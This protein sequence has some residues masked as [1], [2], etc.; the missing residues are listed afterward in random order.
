[1][2]RP[3]LIIIV[4]ITLSKFAKAQ[5]DSAQYE[6][7]DST[8]FEDRPNYIGFNLSPLVTGIVGDYNK[9]VK[10]TLIYK[11]NIGYK[12]LRFSLNH[13]RTVHPYPYNS[14]KVIS[15]T[16]TSY[17]ARFNTHDYQSIDVRMGIEELRGYRHARL[18]IGADVILGYASYGES[19]YDKNVV[20]DS[21][22]VYRIEDTDFNT[23]TGY[24]DGTYFNFGVDVSFGF[25]WFLSDDFLFTFQ[26]TPQFNYNFK[27]DGTKSDDLNVLPD[28]RNFADFKL[29]YFDVML[30]YKF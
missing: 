25:D 7:D 2:L 14:Y 15:T 4:V 17:Y 22:G 28:P 27:I 20:M 9:D 30:V 8:Y 3:L 19:Y 21:A 18:H 26:I 1:M 23:P 29:T 12:N 10:F 6:I 11:R 5:V 16:D 13:L 24:T